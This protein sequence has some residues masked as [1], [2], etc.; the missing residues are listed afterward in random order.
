MLFDLKTSWGTPTDSLS[1]ENTVLV[2]EVAEELRK[3]KIGTGMR[4]ENFTFCILF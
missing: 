3:A 4:R 1:H 2:A